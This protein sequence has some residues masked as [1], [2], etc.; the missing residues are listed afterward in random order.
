MGKESTKAPRASA[1]PKAPIIY[2]NDPVKDMPHARYVRDMIPGAIL[3]FGPREDKKPVNNPPVTLGMI[4]RHIGIRLNDR[5]LVV[6]DNQP[7]TRFKVKIETAKEFQEHAIKHGC[8]FASVN[9]YTEQ[10]TPAAGD[11]KKKWSANHLDLCIKDL[12]VED[13]AEKVYHWLCTYHFSHTHLN[14]AAA[15]S[16]Y[17]KVGRE[18]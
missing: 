12:S 9:L 7:D 16:L 13:V 6:G 10:G 5:I 8:N 18:N 11:K 17:V 4:Q 1:L 2:L 3:A 14:R 15:S